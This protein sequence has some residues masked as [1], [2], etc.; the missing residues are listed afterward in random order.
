MPAPKKKILHKFTLNEI[1]GVDRGAQAGA[2]VTIMKRK[3]DFAK[4][5]FADALEDMQIEES[6]RTALDDM[7]TLNSALRRSIEMVFEDDGITDKVA[8]VRESLAEFVPAVE[9]LVT[10]AVGEVEDDLAAE[11]AETPTKSEGGKKFPAKDYAYV[12]DPQK[13]STWKLRLT[14]TPG[15]DPDPRIVGA[16]VAALGPG[17]RGQKVQIPADDKAAVITRVRAAWKKANP[18][19]GVEDMPGVLKKRKDQTMDTD[20]K[21][22][23]PEQTPDMEKLQKQLEEITARAERAETIA[24]LSN[25]ERDYFNKLDGEENQDKFLELD[26]EARTTEVKKAAEE[27]PVIFTAADGSDFRK[28]DDPRLVK[29]AKQAETDR[30]RADE[31]VEKQLKVELTKRAEDELPSLPG[32]VDQKVDLLK[33]IDSIQ[34]EETREAIGKLLKAGNDGASGAFKSEGTVEG[35]PEGSAEDKLNKLAETKA[36][37]DSISFEKAYTE[38]LETKEGK[39]LYQ[40]MDSPQSKE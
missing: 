23:D 21:I 13:P 39:L 34:E 30:K 40:E 5:A 11:K 31:A 37:K 8:A 9:S 17:F 32:T 19:K 10:E 38:V 35:A 15:G 22:K 12:P 25:E 2:V 1:S 18:D 7:W 29:M 27:D 28:S 3:D 36:E 4:A 16:A 24:K 20:G 26:T 6:V 33:A 14:N